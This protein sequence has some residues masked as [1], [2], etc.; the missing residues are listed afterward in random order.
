MPTQKLISQNLENMYGA[1]FDCGVEKTG[2]NH[3]DMAQTRWD[4]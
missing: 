2:D 4:R 3:P 1:S